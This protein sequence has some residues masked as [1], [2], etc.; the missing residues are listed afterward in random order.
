METGR[1]DHRLPIA[2][3]SA[4]L[5]GAVIGVV[6]LSGS[7]ESSPPTPPPS[8]CLARWNEDPASLRYGRHN[9]IGHRY[10]SAQVRRLSVSGEDPRSGEGNCAVVFP[11]PTLD[12]EPFFA[13]QLATGD[14]WTPIAKLP[15]IPDVRLA[16]L[17]VE[18]QSA[19]NA[20]LHPDGTLSPVG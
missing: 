12:S 5:L 16:E 10:T 4:L 17:Q 13:G 9:Y 1:A 14:R 15:T 19:A 7:S 6:V 20:S 18:A 11:A 8:G 2:V 3:A